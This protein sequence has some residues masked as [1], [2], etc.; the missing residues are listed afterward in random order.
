MHCRRH[1][2][3]VTSI[4][5]PIPLLVLFW[6]ATR[7]LDQDEHIKWLMLGQSDDQLADWFLLGSY[8]L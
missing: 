1:F 3:D 8:C 4:G 5:Q 7:S 6:S 2:I